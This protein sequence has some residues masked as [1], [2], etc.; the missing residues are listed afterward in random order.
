MEDAVEK[1][2]VHY[3]PVTFEELAEAVV[4][5][6]AFLKDGGWI[7]NNGVLVPEHDAAHVQWGGGW[8]MPTSKEL[9]D[10]C[11]K[12][13]WTWKNVNGVEGYV[14]RGYGDYASSSI[15]L[16]CTGFVRKNSLHGC[17]SSGNFEDGYYWLS[18]PQAHVGLSNARG[19][20]FYSEGWVDED[21][22]DDAHNAD[23]DFP[24]SDG[25]PIRPV[26]GF[27]K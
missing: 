15:F 7:T 18:V 13:L 23:H 4:R 2:H 24:R 22:L 9:Q 14:V 5:D 20:H 12:C 27:T 16:P 8:R 3:A 1:T 19:L 26:Q 6:R 10:L 11:H 17:D 25:L 21:S